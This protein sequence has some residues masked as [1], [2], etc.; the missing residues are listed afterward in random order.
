MNVANSVFQRHDTRIQ[1]FELIDT[2]EINSPS[3]KHKLSQAIPQD[4]KPNN[5]TIQLNVST[6]KHFI[7][8]I[9][10]ITASEILKLH[11]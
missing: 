9:V 4:Q 2:T 7:L 1:H 6:Y 8:S 11:S 3:R 10:V 5:S